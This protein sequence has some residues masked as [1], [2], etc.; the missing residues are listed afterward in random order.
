MSVA[1]ITLLVRGETRVHT[2]RKLVTGVAARR[3][4]LGL[5][6]LGVHVVFV[7]EPLYAELAHLRREAYPRPL[8]VNGRRVT[9][10]AH[11]ARGVGEV[12]RVTISACVV[13]RKSWRNAVVG[14]LVTEG[15]VLRLR[16][17]LRLFVVERRFALDDRSLFYVERRRGGVGV[18]LR[19]GLRLGRG[20][21]GRLLRA[22]ASARGDEENRR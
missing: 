9:D 22:A 2:V 14:A 12:L 10:Y 16:L 17:V 6:L 11:L 18:R 21:G 20:F 4:P 19:R 5:H 13:L 7:R 15:A 1:A 8:R 3:L